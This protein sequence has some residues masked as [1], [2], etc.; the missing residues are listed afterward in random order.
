MQLLPQALPVVHVRQHALRGPAVDPTP[1]VLPPPP[2]PEPHA[3]APTAS[4][5]T[6]SASTSQVAATPRRILAIHVT[7]DASLEHGQMGRMTKP[8]W[9]ERGGF[10]ERLAPHSC[11]P[12]GT[13][14]VCEGGC[15]GCA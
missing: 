11:V 2:A 6:S 5:G 4:I 1:P 15:T 7:E 12:K 3:V 14:K 13:R 10:F 9:F 8:S